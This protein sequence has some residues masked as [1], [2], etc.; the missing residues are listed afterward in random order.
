MNI[1]DLKTG[2]CVVVSAKK[3]SG[4]KVQLMFAERI[5]NPNLRPTSI[6]GLLNQS[7][8]RFNVSAKPRYAWHSGEITDIKTA[9]GIDCSSLTEE[10]QVMELGHVNPTING[11]SLSIQITETTNGSEYDVANFETRAKR[12]GKDGDFIL[13]ENGSY[14]Y[15]KSDVVLGDA[16]HVFL[17]NTRRADSAMSLDSAVAEAIAG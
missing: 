12:A 14:I 1:E 11:Q 10:G 15:V 5:A 17:S 4:D 7:D 2:E 16:K 9:L 6:V 8:E 13:S 3:V